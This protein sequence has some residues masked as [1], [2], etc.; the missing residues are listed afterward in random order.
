MVEIHIRQIRLNE[1][2][3]MATMKAMMKVKQNSKQR[4]KEQDL[5]I[6]IIGKVRM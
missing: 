4:E 2:I 6:G 3:K 5:V 1:P